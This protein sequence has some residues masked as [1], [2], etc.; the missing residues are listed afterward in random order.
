VRASRAGTC[1]EYKQASRAHSCVLYHSRDFPDGREAGQL[2]H[3]GKLKSFR[4][5]SANRRHREL[6]PQSP[7]EPSTQTADM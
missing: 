4:P 7:V 5:R 6:S 1:G 3:A 2:Q